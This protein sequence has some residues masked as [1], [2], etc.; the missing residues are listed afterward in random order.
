MYRFIRANAGCFDGFE[1]VDTRNHKPGVPA[2]VL[3]TVRKNSGTNQVVLHVLN[4]DYDPQAKS[5]KPHSNVEVSLTKALIAPTKLYAKLL[6]FD[7]AP[8]Q[9]DLVQEADKVSVR[10]PELKLWTLVVLE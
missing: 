6:S 9:V 7:K 1:A 8:Q 2:N 5:M 10:I 3:V 4:R